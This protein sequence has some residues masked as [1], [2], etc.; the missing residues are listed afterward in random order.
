MSS[1][2]EFEKLLAEGHF[3]Q[4]PEHPVWGRSPASAPQTITRHSLREAAWRFATDAEVGRRFLDLYWR[5]LIRD[6]GPDC[7]TLDDLELLFALQNELE[8]DLLTKL[9]AGELVAFWFPVGR[10]SPDQIAPSW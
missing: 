7:L 1:K 4:N 6:E 5:S 10:T 3:T 2:E 8:A 9:R